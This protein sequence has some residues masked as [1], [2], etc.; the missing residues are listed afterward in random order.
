MNNTVL[1]RYEELAQHA[2][3]QWQQSGRNDKIIIQVGSA[4]CENAAGATEVWREFERN[5]QASGRDDIILHQVGCTGRCSREPIVGVLMPGRMPVKYQRVTRDS[6]HQIF[7]RHIQ[8]G[9]PVAELTLDQTMPRLK[10]QV[11][12][13]EARHCGTRGDE[14]IFTVFQDEINRAGLD[15]EENTLIHVGAL[16]F[17]S[18]HRKMISTCVMVRPENTVYFVK[19]RKDVQEIVAQHLVEGQIV[20]RLRCQEDPISLRFFDLYGDA[21]FFNRQTRI[22]LRNAGVINPE[23]LYE[24]IHYNG[25]R[26]LSLSLSNGDPDWLVERVLESKLR[27]R[28]GG[29]YP[30]G[31]KW[32]DAHR[33][34]NDQRYLICNADEG[35]PG[36]FMDRSMLESD[37]YSVIE[38]MIIGGYAI[39]A[40][41]GFFYVRAE[42]PLAIKRIEKALAECRKHGLLGQNILGSDFSMDLE[43]RLG[44]GAFVCGEETALIHSIEGERGQPRIRPPFPT[45]S[46]LWGKPT[47]I[48]NVETFANIAPL[49]LYGSDW[50][51]SVGTEFSGGTKVFALAGKIQHTGLVEVPMGTTLREVVY[52]IGGG[53]P[54]GKQLKAIQTGG[55]AGGVI[56]AEYLD[57][58]ID[59]DTLG[60]L[61]SIMG[62]GGMIVLDEDDCMVDVAK[63]FMTFC[64]GESCGKCTPCREGTKRMLE[65][66]ERITMG[67]GEMEDLDKLE[68]LASLVK[69][70]SL[71]GLG[72]AAPNPILSTLRHFR[73][74]Y[75]PHVKEKRCPARKCK[76]LIHYEIDP[77]KCVGC[78]MCARN[79]PTN[80][81]SGGRKEVHVIDQVECIKCGRCF[82][83]CRFDAVNRK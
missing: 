36:A 55:P 39:G 41:R 79:C 50:F 48:N 26:A 31:R 44:A 45:E 29:G 67:K 18:I 35:D 16:G 74:E 25:F 73:D 66:L 19:D 81:I 6:A 23:S 32:K 38:G 61:G 59:F 78:T 12:L 77:A 54:G 57:M 34:A 7:S 43:V 62:S 64:Q 72:R 46:G 47:V 37:P 56:P 76:T 13:C 75:E 53:I 51:A 83:V 70:T 52:N 42:Y 40:T 65:I 82:D 10:R 30:T 68:R 9:E 15:P 33:H 2:H 5:I 27:G 80:C 69:N 22:S 49:L 3:T 14:D 24:Y 21:A 20:D 4:T 63:F 8:G 71:C 60:R 1:S 28:G 17:C 58:P 11:I